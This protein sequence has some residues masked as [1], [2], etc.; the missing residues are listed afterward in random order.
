ME[1]LVFLPALNLFLWNR[2]AMSAKA[3]PTHFPVL[4]PFSAVAGTSIY[5]YDF[6]EMNDC[7]DQFSISIV[8]KTK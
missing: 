7:G 5:K 3:M 4:L 6:D 8:H 2:K 1:G